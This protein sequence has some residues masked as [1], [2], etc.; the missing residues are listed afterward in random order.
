MNPDTWTGKF[1]LNTDGYVRTY[2]F[3]NR[4][5]KLCGFKNIRIRVD[6]VLAKLNEFKYI[7]INFALACVQTSPLPQEKLSSPDF[8]L[9]RGDVC[10]QVT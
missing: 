8:C 10:T 7:P 3:L 6:K 5:R 2:K 1:D 4:K 9:R